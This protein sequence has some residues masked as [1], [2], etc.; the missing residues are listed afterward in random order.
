[1][2]N[3]VGVLDLTLG[4]PGLMPDLPKPA[5][6][7]LTIPFGVHSLAKGRSHRVLVG[8]APG[9]ATAPIARAFRR[10]SARPR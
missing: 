8:I 5:P 6:D 4:P 10:T 1:M 9:L 7:R 2:N 3:A